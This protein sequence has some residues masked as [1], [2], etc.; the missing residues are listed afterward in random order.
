VANLPNSALFGA[1][2][3]RVWTPPARELTPQTTRGFEVIEFAESVLGLTLFPWQKWLFIHALELNEDRSYRFETV[4]VEVA[5]QNG[6]TL[7]MKV[8]SLWRMYLDRA[9]LVI[10]TAQ[11][12]DTSEEAWLAAVEL[13]ESVPDLAAEIEA[14]DKAAG[15]KQLR[16]KSGERYKIA[17]ASRRGGRG[18]S[19]DLVLLDELRE[20]Q[21]WDSWGAV[22]KTTMA[23]PQSQVWAFSNAGDR[24]SVV[25]KHLRT[26]AI[27]AV[28]EN[29][30]SSLALFEWSASDNCDILDR[31]GWAQANPS[32]GYLINERSIE[33]A[34]STDPEN[35]FRTEVLCQW[36][37]VVQDPPIDLDAWARCRDEEATI[38]G[39]VVFA[40]DVAPDAR[41]AAICA[42]SNRGDGVFV[43]DVVEHHGGI[44]WV[45][46]R[47]VELNQHSPVAIV[48]DPRSEAGQLLPD[49]ARAGVD[50]TMVK[51]SDVA[52]ACGAFASAVRAGRV[53][54]LGQDSLDIAVSGATRRRVGESWAFNRRDFAVDISPL[55][56][57]AL[58]VRGCATAPE[59]ASTPV[60][61]NLNDFV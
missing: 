9:P 51:T 14:V 1:E 18:L 50:V 40:V 3:P 11:N 17:A 6:K 48:L 57:A 43:I 32:L 31:E 5:R 30:V 60:L 27:A 21:T 44:E 25:L 19:G 37:D 16:L 54:H 10:G 52:A 55:Y 39:D 26:Q 20:H 36:V 8:L 33:A 59:P 41:S 42:S 7:C 46:P 56:A 29:K 13:A 4:V 34:A 61:I 58:A 12:L 35:V 23:R 22:T 15:R 49:L 45:V 2:L 53:R 47:M 28:A 38:T 24:F